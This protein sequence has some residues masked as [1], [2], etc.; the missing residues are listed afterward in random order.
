MFILIQ[1]SIVIAMRFFILHRS[2]FQALLKASHSG[3]NT[4]NYL[5]LMAIA[6]AD[7]LLSL[8]LS[9]SFLVSRST[10]L[11]PWSS[12]SVIHKDFHHI[13]QISAFNLPSYWG[14][15]GILALSA[16]SEWLG[17]LLTLVFFVFF[18]VSDEAIRGYAKAWIWL[19]SHLRLQSKVVDSRSVR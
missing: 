10:H 13:D 2:R 14:R 6:G 8:P 3:L 11:L 18:G 4:S 1:S 7:L 15:P 12:W 9:I 5:R 16:V 19:C 17:P